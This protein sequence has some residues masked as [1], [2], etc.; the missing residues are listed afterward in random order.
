MNSKI[1]CIF[2][3]GFNGACSVH[4]WNGLFKGLNVLY[5]MTSVCGH[6]KQFYPQKLT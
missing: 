1:L 2:F 4:E 5:K 3:Q 6:V